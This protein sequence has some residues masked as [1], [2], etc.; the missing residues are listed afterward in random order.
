MKTSR[1]LS[2]I[3]LLSFAPYSGLQEVKRISRHASPSKYPRNSPTGQ[4][5]IQKAQEKRDRKNALRL[6]S[7]SKL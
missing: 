4:I 2:A 6:Q 5:L 1:L 7:W 3:A